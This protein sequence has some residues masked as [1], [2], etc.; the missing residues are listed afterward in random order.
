MILRFFILLISELKKTLQFFISNESNYL[1]NILR[2]SY[3]ARLILRFH[4]TIQALNQNP[5]LYIDKGVRKFRPDD[6]C[7]VVNKNLEMTKN[8][9]KYIKKFY[10]PIIIIMQRALTKIRICN[11]YRFY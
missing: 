7:K 3:L 8:Y 10:L 1:R 5:D 4:L 2:N 6:E 9:I 11:F